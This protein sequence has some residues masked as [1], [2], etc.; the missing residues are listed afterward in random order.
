M[1][2][3]WNNTSGEFW[4]LD[5]PD[6]RHHGILNC[7][8]ASGISIRFLS[9]HIEDY[10][11][12]HYREHSQEEL[13]V[14]GYLKSEGMPS[15]LYAGVKSHIPISL[16]G[17]RIEGHH[18]TDVIYYADSALIGVL[19]DRE[20]KFRRLSVESP[21]LNW[22]RWF[23]FDD[24]P[25][26]SIPRPALIAENGRMTRFQMAIPKDDTAKHPCGGELSIRYDLDIVPTDYLGYGVQ[27]YAWID[28]IAPDNLSYTEML[29]IVIRLQSYLSIVV[30]NPIDI[31]KVQLFDSY[32]GNRVS[33]ILYQFPSSTEWKRKDFQN[34]HVWRK[35]SETAKA[36]GIANWLWSD[37]VTLN[38]ERM[39]SI[40]YERSSRVED[41]FRSIAAAAEGIL[42]HS[43]ENL[44]KKL[45]YILDELFSEGHRHKEW[46]ENM[47]KIRIELSHSNYSQYDEVETNMG[48]WAMYRL[49]TLFLFDKYRIL[50]NAYHNEYFLDASENM[51]KTR[52]IEI[53]ISIDS[54]T[55]RLYLN[56]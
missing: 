17:C 33:E 37:I 12:A 31:D 27:R 11:S 2:T 22:W 10:N 46:A 30:H 49:L 23:L 14:H 40:F 4:T 56:I 7:S 41:K 48:L 21:H 54:N 5:Q 18:N 25:F 1:K 39:V 15:N 6:F 8:D 34:R 13:I 44:D 35:F 20:T 50:N 55:G 32:N 38:M 16:F 53:P 19:A 24:C 45:L 29:D 28:I 43:N 26:T 42:T 9:D 36:E 51:L 3:S 47:Y 52:S